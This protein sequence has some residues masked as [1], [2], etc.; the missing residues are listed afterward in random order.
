MR[1]FVA[2]LDFG[3][4]YAQ[5]ISRRIRECGVYCEILPHDIACADLKALMPKAIVLSGGPSSVLEDDHPG[6]DPDILTLGLPILGICY[7]L[8]L[9]AVKLG[10]NMARGTSREYG[11]ATI[12]IDRHTDL[13]SGLEDSLHVWMSHGDHVSRPPEGFTVLAHTNSCAIAAMGDEC[14]GLY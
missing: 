5:L 10:G 6:I 1:E 11:P 3:S 4:Q 9:M 8:Q 12:S 13:F 7:G 14:R 2:V